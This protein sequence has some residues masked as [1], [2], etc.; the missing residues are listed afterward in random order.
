MGFGVFGFRLLEGSFLD[1][2]IVELRWVLLIF[3]FFF[4]LG[5]GG[6]ISVEG[7]G[8]QAF[9]PSAYGFWVLGLS[10]FICC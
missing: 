1:T 9:G 5:G 8:V 10:G 6:L 2:G 4:F 7:F 3:P